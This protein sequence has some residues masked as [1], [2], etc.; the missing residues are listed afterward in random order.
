MRQRFVPSYYA[1]GMLNKVQCLQQGSKSVEEYFQELQIGML[2]F[3]LVEN[4]DAAMTRVFGGRNH[5][6]QDVLDYKE[7][8]NITRLFHLACKAERE[9]QERQTRIQTI[10]SAGRTSSWKPGSAFT[11]APNLTSLPSITNK[12]HMVVPT[13]TLPASIAANASHHGTTS[14]SFVA[15]SGCTRDIQYHRCKGYGHVMRD[16]SNK[17]VLLLL[18]N[19]EYDSTSDF[20]DETY[21]MLATNTTGNEV[22]EEYVAAAASDMFLSIVVQHVLSTQ[23]ATMDKNQRHNLFQTKGV[24]KQRAVRIIIDGG[25]CNN[26]VSTYMVDNL[27]LATRPHPHPYHIQWLNQSGKIK[28]TSSVRVPFAMGSY[29]DYVDCDVVSMQVCS[30]LLG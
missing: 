6:I 30:M 20:D 13:T 15:S 16:C 10:F 7:Y 8:N 14:S 11:T 23:V 28:V 21:A 26:L 17:R 4:D 1:R 18:D 3:G 5:K 22:Q 9:V 24:V 25:S 29:N 2:R 27:A 19:G 12:Q